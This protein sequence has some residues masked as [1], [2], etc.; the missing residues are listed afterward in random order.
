MSAFPN[1]TQ[2][3]R[4]HQALQHLWQVQT[5]ICLLCKARNMRHRQT[6]ENPSNTKDSPRSNTPK[7]CPSL[8]NRSPTPRLLPVP[9]SR[10]NLPKSN[11]QEHRL[12]TRPWTG[13]LPKK[14]SNPKDLHLPSNYKKEKFK[15]LKSLD[16]QGSRSK[17]ALEI[18]WPQPKCSNKNCII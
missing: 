2:R 5:K 10:S 14:L 4:E 6:S 18:H 8:G 15:K 13:N 17:T 7:S 1:L 16:L 3:S 12:P 11:S 9:H